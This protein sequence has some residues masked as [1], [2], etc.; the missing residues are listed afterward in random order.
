M[1]DS[2]AGW[3]QQ[4]AALETELQGKAD[5][6]VMPSHRLNCVLQRR[7]SLA[8]IHYDVSPTSFEAERMFSTADVAQ[9][10]VLGWM[11][12][13]I[14]HLAFLRAYQATVGATRQA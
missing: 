9:H 12:A 1:I 8:L 6:M 3:L 7:D 10:G 13:L 5:S 4:Q 2:G 14:I 11:T